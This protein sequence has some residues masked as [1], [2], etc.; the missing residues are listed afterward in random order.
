[1]TPVIAPAYTKL[2]T[3]SAQ[4]AGAASACRSVCPAAGPATAAAGGADTP[5]PAGRPSTA[6][7]TDSGLS[8][9][10]AQSSG[11]TPAATAHPMPAHAAR[12]PCAAVAA[13]RAGNAAMN[14]TVPA[15]E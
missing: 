13:S 9:T 6:R 2:L 8:R 5:S 15:T 7:P 1:M 14:P 3:A 11:A 10:T 4:N 12:H